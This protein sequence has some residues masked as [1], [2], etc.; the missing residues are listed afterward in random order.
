MEIIRCNIADIVF[1]GIVDRI[2]FYHL[3][4]QDNR[5][6][7]F[8]CLCKDIIIAGFLP[9]NKDEIIKSCFQEFSDIL[10]LPANG[11]FYGRFID[12]GNPLFSGSFLEAVDLCCLPGGQG[13]CIGKRNT[14]PFFFFVRFFKV[15][16]IHKKQA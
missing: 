10:Y 15:C 5:Y 1:F 4:C 14:K 8:F 16:F 7:A 11:F 2:H 6:S 9:G 13:F 12:Q 3:F